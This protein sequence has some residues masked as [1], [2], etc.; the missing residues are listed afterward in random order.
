MLGSDGVWADVVGVDDSGNP[1]TEF[2]DQFDQVTAKNPSL[3]NQICPIMDTLK[4]ANHYCKNVEMLGTATDAELEAAAI[5]SPM[6]ATHGLSDGLAALALRVHF[7]DNSTPIPV[8]WTLNQLNR[9][10]FEQDDLT[11]LP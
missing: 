5:I 9:W 11:P 4:V 1:S 7:V 10:L 8:E 2:E 3:K 6:L